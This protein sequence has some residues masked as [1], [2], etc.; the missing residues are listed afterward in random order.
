MEPVSAA[1]TWDGA[2]ICA[3]PSCT[4]SWQS[5]FN[6]LPPDTFKISQGSLHI[7]THTSFKKIPI[8]LIDKNSE[9]VD[10]SQLK[11]QGSVQIWVSVG[12]EH[13]ESSSEEL[14]EFVW[15]ILEEEEQEELEEEEEIEE[16][17]VEEEPVAVAA[18]EVEAV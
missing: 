15:G 12:L 5:A 18:D 2:T 9:A 11:W 17:I 3:D 1:C 4:L 6:D 8:W 16:E 13:F 14:N 10:N 7:N